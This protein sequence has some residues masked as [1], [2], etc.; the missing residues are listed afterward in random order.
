MRLILQENKD[1]S[2]A[3]NL[4]YKGTLKTIIVDKKT[5]KILFEFGSSGI[6]SDL[7]RK[8]NFDV[9]RKGKDYNEGNISVY[10][11]LYQYDLKGQEIHFTTIGPDNPLT[12][13][14]EKQ[15][16]SYPYVFAFADTFTIS[17]IEEIAMK[18]AISGGWR[19]VEL[20]IDD[21]A[22]QIDELEGIIRVSQQ[23]VTAI[24]S[25]AAETTLKSAGVEG[26]ESKFIDLIRQTGV[27]DVITDINDTYTKLSKYTKL[28]S[29][30]A[31]KAQAAKTIYT[32]LSTYANLV[33]PVNEITILVE[34]MFSEAREAQSYG[35]MLVSDSVPT[36]TYYTKDEANKNGNMITRVYVVAPSKPL[37]SEDWWWY[38]P[39]EN[40]VWQ[41]NSEGF[42]INTQSIE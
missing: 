25:S 4:N 13:E 8:V 16:D 6:I 38:V 9:P 32:N 15:V 22:S 34:K 23:K 19:S 20:D 29:E 33:D 12:Q 28:S 26:A 37:Y 36:V 21:I 2:N 35:P 17:L 30:L 1:Y 27:I 41:I 31:K 11:D 39:S 24:K 42:V 18:D 5:N 14:F 10:F 3:L 40:A 7:I